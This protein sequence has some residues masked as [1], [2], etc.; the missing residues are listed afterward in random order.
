[1]SMHPAKWTAETPNSLHAVLRLPRCPFGTSDER[2][3]AAARTPFRPNRFPQGRDQG[4]AVSRQRHAR[5]A[6]G[7]EP[8]RALA[9]GRPR[10]HRGADDPRPGSPQAGQ[11]QPRAHLPLLRRPALVR[12]VR[13]VGHL[14][15]GRGQLRVPRLRRPLRQRAADARR[16][17]RPQR[18]QRGELQEPSRPSSSG[19]WATNA[20]GAARTSSTP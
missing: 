18:R 9:R 6:Q 8:A 3:A 2:S 14:A 11:L 15:G 13:R 1:M 20:A 17:H 5:Q 10:R 12:T 19:R 4:P 16:D 7:R